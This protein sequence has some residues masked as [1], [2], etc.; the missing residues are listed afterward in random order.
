MHRRSFVASL[1]VAAACGLASCGSGETGAGKNVIGVSLLTTTNPFFNE[2]RD[3]MQAA[4][5]PKGRSSSWRPSGRA[6]PRVRCRSTRSP[7][8]R[9]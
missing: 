7:S 3:S 2:I 1:F 6:S 9:K 4:A 5:A 8:V